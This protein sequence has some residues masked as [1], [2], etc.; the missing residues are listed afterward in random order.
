MRPS[1]LILLLALP[2]F[3]QASDADKESL[4]GIKEFPVV[5]EKLPP[6]TPYLTVDQLRVAVKL[7]LRKAGVTVI[8]LIPLR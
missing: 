6:K 7:R 4:A 1:F 2:V 3:L 8:R 5:V